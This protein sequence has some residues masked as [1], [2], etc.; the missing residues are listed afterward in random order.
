MGLQDEEED[1]AF[2][3]VTGAESLFLTYEIATNAI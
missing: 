3:F 2:D 1:A